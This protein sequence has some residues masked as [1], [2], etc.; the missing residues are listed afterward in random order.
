[1]FFEIICV[2]ILILL[3][4]C[5][6][7]IEKPRQIYNALRLQGVPGDPFIP[8]FGQL[9]EHRRYYES[10]KHMEFYM[11][12]EKKHGSR[13]I[14]PIGPIVNLVI[15]DAD[16][17]SEVLIK[18]YA[19]YKKPKLFR[20]QIGS[21]LGPVNLI[22]AEGDVHTRIREM[23]NPA[24]HYINLQSLTSLMCQE[25]VK[26]I[27]SWTNKYSNTYFDIQTEIHK[28]S[29]TIICSSSFGMTVTHE[30]TNE[31]CQLL[32][33]AFDALYYRTN[34]FPIFQI[35]ILNQLPIL[36]KPI[37]DKLGHRF[38]SLARQMIE[39]RRC[40][41][42][43]NHS[44]QNDLLDL[45]LTAEDKEGKKF[46]DEE[47]ENEAI[48]F[49][50]AG[51]ETTGGLLSWCLYILLTNPEVFNDCREEVDRVLN[52]QIPDYS[53][54]Q[55]LIVIDAVL[56]ET[57]RLYPPVSIIMRECI[58]EHTTGEEE[59]RIPVG[60]GVVFNFYNLH[61]SDKY[62]KDPLK[63]DY[64]RWIRNSNGLKPKLAHRFCYLPFLAGV[65]NC[66]GQNF[67]LLEA[68]IVLIIMIQKLNIEIKPDHKVVPHHRITLKAKY[69]IQAKIQPRV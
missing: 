34:H 38:R 9:K 29:L 42:N 17:I 25:T 40:H 28:L 6:K 43:E 62:W 1:M 32:K 63:F 66:I 52:G 35:P 21:V 57:L 46:S 58:R 37:I 5:Y 14:L 30:L 26:V 27:E 31:L 4:I 8:I 19:F 59:I 53:D 47:I 18:K 41:M 51:H 49:V 7:L 33:D 15:L 24:F 3:I 12:L 20:T 10:D 56:H 45:L 48:T 2:I 44:D 39:Q 68:K 36:K 67:G 50:L 23:L 69:G 22:L 61:R 60:A 16:L 11:D 55:N 54:L 13:F 64:K 65:R